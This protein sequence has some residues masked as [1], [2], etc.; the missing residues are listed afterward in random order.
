MPCFLYFTKHYK[1]RIKINQLAFNICL[2]FIN[3]LIYLLTRNLYYKK[4]CKIK[5]FLYKLK[6]SCY[7]YTKDFSNN[8]YNASIVK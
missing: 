8:P 6:I 3:T 4:Y 2:Y 7:K 5:I 1:T